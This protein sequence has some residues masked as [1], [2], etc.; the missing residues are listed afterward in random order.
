MR[1]KDEQTAP[2]SQKSIKRYFLIKNLHKKNKTNK[3]TKKNKTK[4]NKTKKQ[5]TKQNKTKQKQKKTFW[6]FF[7][8]FSH[9]LMGNSPRDRQRS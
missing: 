2:S 9:F 7:I 1:E 8:I 6:M 3:K 4:Q 5:K